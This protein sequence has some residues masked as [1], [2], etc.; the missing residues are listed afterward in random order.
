MD[1]KGSHTNSYPREAEGD[2][3]TVWEEGELPVETEKDFNMLSNWLWIWWSKP[4]E[5]KEFSS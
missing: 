2:L 5:Y 3:N 4:K 1:P